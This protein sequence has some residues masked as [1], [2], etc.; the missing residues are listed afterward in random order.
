MAIYRLLKF[1]A[2]EPEL[3]ASMTTAYDDALRI[4]QLNDRQDPITEALAKRII[5]AAQ[6][7]ETDPARLRQ[8]ALDSLGT[9]PK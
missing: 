4:L 6:E 5:E 9:R 3:I 8:R 2:F 1:G 7:G